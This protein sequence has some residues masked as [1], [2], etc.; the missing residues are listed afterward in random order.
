M[1]F[2]DRQTVEYLIE[3]GVLKKTKDPE[4]EQYPRNRG[5][6]FDTCGDC[7]RFGEIYDYQVSLVIKDGGSREMVHVI[8]G[9]GGGLLL[10]EDCVVSSKEAA[11]L[12]LSQIAGAVALKGIPLVMIY[13]HFPCGAAGLEDMSARSI[14]QALVEAK[15]AVHTRVPVMVRELVESKPEK[16]KGKVLGVDIPLELQVAIKV[17][18]DYGPGKMFTYRVDDRQWRREYNATRTLSSEMSKHTSV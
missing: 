17:H 6:I 7:A 12:Y 16:F 8:T 4:I 15:Q 10:A 13:G 14:I 11:H 3:Q 9:N 5:V 2:R 1:A 18:L